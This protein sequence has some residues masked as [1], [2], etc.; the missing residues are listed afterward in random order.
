MVVAAAL[1][2]VAVWALSQAQRW[3]HSRKIFFDESQAVDV[4]AA[5]ASN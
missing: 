2:F 5:G 3:M 4:S 1:L